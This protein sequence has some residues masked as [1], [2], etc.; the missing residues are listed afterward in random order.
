MC[1]NAE[2]IDFCFRKSVGVVLNDIISISNFRSNA[3]F[4]KAKNIIENYYFNLDSSFA[5]A[6][7]SDS[8]LSKNNCQL[9]VYVYSLTLVYAP[10]VGNV[11]SETYLRHPSRKSST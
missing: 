8:M 2:F 10:A 11:F 1:V 7:P 3:L 5:H 6:Y 4:V 9:S